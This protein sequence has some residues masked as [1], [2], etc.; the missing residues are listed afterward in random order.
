MIEK[1]TT[2][3]LM[4]MHHMLLDRAYARGKY[5]EMYEIFGWLHDIEEDW[6]LAGFSDKDYLRGLVDTFADMAIADRVQDL[7][8]YLLD[9]KDRYCAPDDAPDGDMSLD[10][11]FMDEFSLDDLDDEEHM[12]GGMKPVYYQCGKALEMGR[13]KMS[14]SGAPGTIE[15][16]IID[17][18]GDNAL[19]L[20]TKII[21]IMTFNNLY[22]NTSWDQSSIRG[23][24]EDEFYAN[25]FTD[26]E[27]EHI[28]VT[29]NENGKSDGVHGVM[30]D[31]IFAPTDDKI[32]LLSGKE[33]NKYLVGERLIRAEATEYVKGQNVPSVIR[34]NY[35]WW[36]RSMGINASTACVIDYN[37]VNGYGE[38]VNSA[39]VGVR[40]AM[41]IKLG[42]R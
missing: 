33:V 32:F 23:W 5:D 39:G 15:W 11:I 25:S 16:T 30:T 24:L 38:F 20:S 14:Q 6:I 9:Y 21:E 13:Y 27:K 17:R 12:I 1:Y 34:D 22:E 29:R 41:W 19:V 40:P 28:L 18:E 42:A 26:E 2:E 36:G 10:D 35:R 4:K 3:Y 7:T 8:S 31:N 37:W